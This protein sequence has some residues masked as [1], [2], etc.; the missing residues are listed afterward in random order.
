MTPTESTKPANNGKLIVIFL[1]LVLL[2]ILL[3]GLIV[4]LQR[5]NNVRAFQSNDPKLTFQYPSNWYVEHDLEQFYI[6]EADFN[7]NDVTPI[8]DMYAYSTEDF[9]L[10]DSQL[11]MEQKCEE[12]ISVLDLEA[13]VDEAVVNLEQVNAFETKNMKGCEFIFSDT[14]NS[15]NGY[16]IVYYI[17][18]EPMVYYI[19]LTGTDSRDT[20]KIDQFKSII[21]SLESLE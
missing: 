13:N 4:I 6:A 2:F 1:G 18:K 19:T 5:N 21:K 12:Y 20:T 14:E 9:G 16:W 11:I 15:E 3:V 17:A 7:E 10:S 8:L